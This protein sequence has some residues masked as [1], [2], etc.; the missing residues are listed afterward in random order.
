MSTLTEAVAAHQALWSRELT[1]EE[2]AAIH[3]HCTCPDSFSVPELEP[4]DPDCP[5]HGA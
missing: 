4:E 3:E 2:A 5:V 1:D